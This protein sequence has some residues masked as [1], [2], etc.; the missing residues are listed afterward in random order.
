MSEQ[1]QVEALQILEV[2]A[3]DLMREF[4]VKVPPIPVESI[5]QKPQ[6]GM[7]EEININQ[8]TGSF[9]SIKDQ[10]SPRM[11]MA[12][13]L[14][15]H[16]INCPWGK[17]RDL[18]ALVKSEDDL[19]TFARMLIMPREMVMTMTTGARNPV[20]MSMNFEVPEEDAQKRLMQIAVL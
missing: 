4:E 11:S 9:L 2:A 14:A 7:W 3:S 13:L 10:Y 6:A 16:V 8:L 5:L 19:R 20:V 12:R 1:L 18:S 15:K 17:A